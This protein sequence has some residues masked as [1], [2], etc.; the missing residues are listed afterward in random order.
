MF[1][2]GRLVS[3]ANLNNYIGAQENLQTVLVSN[4]LDRGIGN[5]S[6]DEEYAELEHFAVYAEITTEQYKEYLNKYGKK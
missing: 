2:T 3:A 6:Y 4:N 1:G 5:K